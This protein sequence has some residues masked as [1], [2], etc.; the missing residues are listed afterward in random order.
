MKVESVVIGTVAGIVLLQS[1][2][3]PAARLASMVAGWCLAFYGVRRQSAEGSAIAL[4]GLA[5]SA[6]G[7]T[8]IH[9]SRFLRR[10]SETLP[11]S[12]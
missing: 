9:L 7:L 2:W 10:S 8:D 6:K 11:S 12:T 4:A 5:L 3:S 1:D